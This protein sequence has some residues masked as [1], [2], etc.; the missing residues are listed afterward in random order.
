MERIVHLKDAKYE[1]SGKSCFMVLTQDGIYLE[2]ENIAFRASVK[3][4]AMTWQ[5]KNLE[6]GLLTQEEYI[7]LKIPR[8]PRRIIEE[9][10][11]LGRII[12]E[13]YKSEVLVL[14]FY[15]PSTQEFMNIVPTQE[16][17]PCSVKSTEC[18]PAPEGWY[19][20]GTVHTHPGRAFHSDEDQIDESGLDGA[21][22][23]IGDLDKLL[24]SFDVEVVVN[25]R[26]FKLPS[27][28]VIEPVDIPEEW[29]S[30][31]RKASDK[32]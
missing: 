20:I 7:E 13:K 25:G 27:D 16:V 9:Q 6:E 8:I 19:L 10:V 17:S 21:H 22:L 12:R 29:I 30:K 15:C 31:I 3:L 18:I 23:T 32:S 24:P 2:K 11:A 5:N 1:P 14:L 28:Q 26:R 4:G